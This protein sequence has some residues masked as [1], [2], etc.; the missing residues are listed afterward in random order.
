MNIITMLQ[1]GKNIVRRFVFEKLKSL[2]LTLAKFFCNG[3]NYQIMKL[4]NIPYA[5]SQNILAI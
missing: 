3:D 1:L 2:H 4:I 5:L